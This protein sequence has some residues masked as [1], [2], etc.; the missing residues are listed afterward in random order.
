MN[1]ATSSLLTTESAL[2]ANG[3]DP[4]AA[5]EAVIQERNNLTSQNAQLWKLIEK[6]RAMYNSATKEIDKL[7][8]LVAQSSPSPPVASKEKEPQTVSEKTITDASTPPTVPKRPD[9]PEK[10]EA[11]EKPS[12]EK[13]S[14][15]NSE[16]QC[17]FI[18]P[19]LLF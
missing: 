6:Q 11:R 1:G 4:S 14:R 16:D 10:A 18:S 19:F 15:S 8:A 2:Q 17:K 5:L 7:R 12:R 3:H 9:R 13:L